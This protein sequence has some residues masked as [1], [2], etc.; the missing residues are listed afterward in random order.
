VPPKLVSDSRVVALPVPVEAWH[1]SESKDA[2]VVC[3]AGN[4]DKK[5]LDLIAGAWPHTDLTDRRLIVTGIEPD[6]GRAFL[7]SRDVPEPSGLEWAG[8][9]PADAHRD[10]LERAEI[11]LSASRFEDYGIAQLEA[12]GT[13]SLLVTSPS[14]GPYEALHVARRLEPAL[15]ARDSSPEGLALALRAALQMPPEARRAYRERAA[16]LLAPYSEEE[17]RSRLRDRVLPLLGLA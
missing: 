14:A 11:Y 2:I 3:Y 10:L 16:A 5:G 4:P 15:V 12:L 17:L 6:R 9:L 8:L 1:G 7:R 13:G